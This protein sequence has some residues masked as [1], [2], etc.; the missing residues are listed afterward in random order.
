MGLTRSVDPVE[1]PL[2]L[3]EAK[4]HLRITGDEEEQD[5]L[6]VI[7]EARDEIETFA[8]RVLNAA[9]Y[10]LTLPSFYAPVERDH[11]EYY[12]MGGKIILP[13]APVQSITSIKYLDN[14]GVQQTLSTDVYGV[15]TTIEPARIY[16]KY[17]QF[18]PAARV[19]TA[20]I[21]IT[22]VAGYTSRAAIPQRLVGILK[23]L[24]AYFWEYRAAASEERLQQIPIGVYDQL[25]D[26]KLWTVGL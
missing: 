8:S 18:Y 16:Q 1:L 6:A 12:W 3:E 26:Y 4:R 9:T 5:I 10:V 7:A 19:T 13:R 14:D 17:G 22:F 11:Q 23:R 21:E 2:E 15:D 20:S 25:L 24:L